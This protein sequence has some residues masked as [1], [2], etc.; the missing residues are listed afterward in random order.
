MCQGCLFVRDVGG[1]MLGEGAWR[2][3]S[4]TSVYV[5]MQV[6]HTIPELNPCEGDIEESLAIRQEGRFQ[7]RS[8][9]K[10]PSALP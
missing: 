5:P 2:R 10:E 6:E 9:S 3:I 8:G 1:E 7:Y 4:D